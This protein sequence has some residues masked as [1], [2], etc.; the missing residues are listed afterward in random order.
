MK[1]NYQI[2]LPYQFHRR[3]QS[4]GWVPRFPHKKMKTMFLSNK[5]KSRSLTSTFFPL[6][7]SFHILHYTWLLYEM[8]TQP[9]CFFFFCRWEKK[10]IYVYMYSI[11]CKI[12]VDGKAI[13][14]VKTPMNLKWKY[15]LFSRGH[16]T[17]HL[18]VSVGR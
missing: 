8:I 1:E 10:Y 4:A 11:V 5:W 17:L 6:N 14:F 3:P 18:A 16:A 9:F 7:E 12:K 13:S 15:T 2:Y